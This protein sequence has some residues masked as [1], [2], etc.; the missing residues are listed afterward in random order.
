MDLGG[1]GVGS[2]TR[3]NV[4]PSQGERNPGPQVP[5]PAR[6]GARPQGHSATLAQIPA[7]LPHHLVHP[8]PQ[9]LEEGQATWDGRVTWLRKE[10][11]ALVEHLELWPHP[12]APGKHVVVAHPLQDHHVHPVLQCKSVV[13]SLSWVGRVQTGHWMWA[14]VYPSCLRTSLSKSNGSVGA[15]EKQLEML[16]S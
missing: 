11:E 12:D 8:V 2:A 15:A 7:L 14:R 13:H 1:S 16:E 5:T 3:D 4:Q 6:S 9:E 10:A